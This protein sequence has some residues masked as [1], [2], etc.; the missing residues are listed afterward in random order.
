MAETRL[1]VID[2]GLGLAKYDAMCKAI[3]VCHSVDEV[4]ELRSKARALEVYAAQAMNTEAERRCCEVRIRAERRAGQLLKETREAGQR[5]VPGDNAGAHRGHPKRSSSSASTLA[6]LKISY[7]QS[8]KWQQLAEVPEEVFERAVT[9][10]PIK[11][12]TEGIIAANRPH[13]EIKPF[14]INVKALA[15]WG[16][17]R[18]FEKD[19]ILDNSSF[20][21]QLELMTDPM[22][23][24][25]ERIAPR[26]KSWLP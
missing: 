15:M 18:D 13:E 19:G 10:R 23:E 4:K 17:L 25:C 6:D 16:R 14:R 22:R 5:A 1:A 7:D 9:E 2:S 21:A 26:L 20:A 3:A 12:T 8:S 24:D 11:P